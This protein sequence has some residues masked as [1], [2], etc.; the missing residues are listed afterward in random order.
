MA[1]TEHEDR[2]L[3]R[4]AQ[5]LRDDDPALAR[6]L[7]GAP[8]TA[9]EWPVI[10]PVAAGLLLVAGGE[11]WH[12]GVCAAIGVVLASVVP[13]IVSIWLSRRA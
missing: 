13:I 2:E 1:L 12:N 4:I 7:E 3:H 10:V 11:H 8:G 6:A 5:R 9:R